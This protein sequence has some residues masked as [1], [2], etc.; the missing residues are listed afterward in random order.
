MLTNQYFIDLWM[1]RLGQRASLRVRQD[2]VAEINSSIIYLE[3]QVFIPWFL[4]AWTTIPLN[5]GD[6]IA[7]LPLTFA[8]EREYTRPYFSLEGRIHF[9]TKRVF[10]AIYGIED[11]GDVPKYYALHGQNLV[12]RPVATIPL[13]LNVAHYVKTGG[14]VVDDTAEATNVWLLNAPDWVAFRALK[15]VAG[16][17]LQNTQKASEFERMEIQAKDDIYRFHL[18]REHQN[19]DYE[20]GGISDGS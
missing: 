17:H 13:T 2:L 11:S 9:L 15:A 5:P 6:G 14:G 3:S 12:L 20:V 4:E 19:Q 8:I 1:S 7:P 16:L 18:A 10:G